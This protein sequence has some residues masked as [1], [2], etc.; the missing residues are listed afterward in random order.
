[1]AIGVELVDLRPGNLLVRNHGQ[2]ATWWLE[3]EGADILLA[4]GDDHVVSR[5]LKQLGAGYW[6]SAET[7]GDA[8]GLVLT[9]EDDPASLGPRG[10]NSQSARSSLKDWRRN[11]EVLRDFDDD[12]GK[13]Q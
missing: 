7:C 10:H 4:I 2:A 5:R 9:A 1:M 3:R 8:E 6:R 13:Y 11:Y 12:Q